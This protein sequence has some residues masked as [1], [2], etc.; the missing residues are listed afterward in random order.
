MLSKQQEGTRATSIPNCEKSWSRCMISLTNS[1]EKIGVGV[2]FQQRYQ[3]W[4]I[5]RM[6]NDDEIEIERTEEND[7]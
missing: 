3:L 6:S 7:R 4:T 1:D 2:Y 5:G